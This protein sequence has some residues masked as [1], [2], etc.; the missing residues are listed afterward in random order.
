MKKVVLLA[1]TLISC[2]NIY[3]Q[4][5]GI[6]TNSPSEKLEVIGNH[7]CPVLYLNNDC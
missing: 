3:A 1:V 6:G 7:Y 4:K 5:V 2:L